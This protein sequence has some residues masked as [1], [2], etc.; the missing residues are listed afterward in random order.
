MCIDGPGTGNELLLLPGLLRKGSWCGVAGDR[1]NNTIALAS[2][3]DN[4]V[5]G[6]F[7]IFNYAHLFALHI[8]YT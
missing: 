6:A 5:G 2:T 3:G 1:W 7:P 8:R 4:E